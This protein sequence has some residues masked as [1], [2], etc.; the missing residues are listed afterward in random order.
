VEKKPERD[1]KNIRDN[2]GLAQPLR[3]LVEALK[4]CWF[5]FAGFFVHCRKLIH[6]EV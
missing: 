6:I 1:G 5:K 3:V 4:G 2:R